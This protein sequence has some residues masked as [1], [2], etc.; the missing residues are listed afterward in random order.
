MSD[1]EEGKW[2]PTN[3]DGHSLTH[4]QSLTVSDFVRSFV[5]SFLRSF[6]PSF[7]RCFVPS[8]LRCF[9]SFVPSFLRSIA[10]LVCSLHYSFLQWFLRC[11][12]PAL[13][14]CFR[15]DVA[16]F[17][18]SFVAMLRCFVPSLRRSF[19]R[20]CFVSSIARSSNR[21][22]VPSIR[23]FVPPA[24]PEFFLS[25]ARSFMH[26][27]VASSL[28]SEVLK[29]LLMIGVL[30]WRSPS[31]SSTSAVDPLCPRALWILISALSA[32][33][34]E[35]WSRARCTSCSCTLVRFASVG[36]GGSRQRPAAAHPFLC[37]R[38]VFLRL[39]F[40]RRSLFLSRARSRRRVR[41][42][43]SATHVDRAASCKCG[44]A[45]SCCVDRRKFQRPRKY[46]V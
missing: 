42:A 28:R 45:R 15:C 43:G 9:C 20:C 4:S 13:R 21:L 2:P 39:C 6:V 22:L 17:L 35:A 41:E 16:S 31:L 29:L 30:F 25:L 7:L 44:P 19:L 46:F 24:P 23:S 38:C 36:R 12:V 27:F 40:P 10:A 18:R 11:D 33:R 1:S 26:C 3:D 34:R 32:S 14:C 37:V 8:F 5:P